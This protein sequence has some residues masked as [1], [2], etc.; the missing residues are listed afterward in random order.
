MVRMLRGLATGLMVALLLG[1]SA[2]AQ[3]IIYVKK[4]ATGANDGS[5]WADAYTSLQDALAAAQAG[6]EIWVAA[7]VYYPDEGTG[8][9]DNDRTLS[10]QMKSGVAIYGGFAG[11]ETDRSQRDWEA[12]PTVLSGDLDQNDI[13][14]DG[15]GKYELLRGNNSLHVVYVVADSLV[16]DG[17]KISG[18]IA[19]DISDNCGGGFYI[20]SSSNV[21][22]YNL[23]IEFNM[24]DQKGGGICVYNSNIEIKNSNIYSNKSGIGGGVY[25]NSSGGFSRFYSVIIEKNISNVGAGIYV[26]GYEAYLSIDDVYFVQ[27][28][29]DALFF[30]LVYGYMDILNSKFVHNKGRNI[31]MRG[32]KEC[33]ILNIEIEYGWGIDVYRSNLVVKNAVINE[34]GIV[35]EESSVVVD[36]VYVFGGIS[37]IKIFGSEA[38]VSNSII[39]HVVG[40]KYQQYSGQY[41][42][43]GGITISGSDPILYNVVIANN[44]ADYGGGIYVN[45][46][47]PQFFNVYVYN[48]MA[49]YDGGGMYIYKSNGSIAKNIILFNNKAVSSGGAI[50][51]KESNFV[52]WNNLSLIHNNADQGGG[53]Y[54]VDSFIALN[55]SLFANNVGK[56]CMGVLDLSSSNNVIQ[57]VASACGLQDGQN[58]NVIGRDARLVVTDDSTGI[59]RL[60]ADS[61]ALDAGDDSVC[62]TED[63]RGVERPQDGDEDGTPRCDIGALEFLPQ[64]LLH[65]PVAVAPVRPVSG[66][67]LRLSRSVLDTLWVSWPPATDADGDVLVYRWELGDTSMQHVYR[68]VWVGT[69][70]SVA[71]SHQELIALL[72]SLG[73]SVGEGRWLAHCVVVW[74]STMLAGG[75]RAEVAGTAQPL[76]L[77]IENSVP[78]LAE[79]LEPADGSVLEV[80]AGG[81]DTLRVVWGASWDA[82]GDALR[83]RWELS[84]EGDFARVWRRVETGDTLVVVLPSELWSLADSVGLGVG[85]RL[86]LYHRVVVSDGHTEV[87]GA[88]RRLELV[89][90]NS[91]PSPPAL[92]LPVVW[93]AVQIAGEPT[94]TL[95]IVWWGVRDPDGDPVYYRWEL[96]HDSLFAQVL[97]RRVTGRDTVVG[98]SYRELADLLDSL[99]TAPGQQQRLYHRV[100]AT[101]SSR[102]EGGDVR[103]VVGPAVPL[104][105]VR[106]QLTA[107]E[108]GLPDRIAFH[109]HYPNPVRAGVV[110]LLLDLPASSQV[111]VEV[112]DMLGRLVRRVPRSRLEAGR[113][114]RLQLEVDDLAAGMYVYRVLVASPGGTHE[115]F[116]G[117]LVRVR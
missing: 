76:F 42:R 64:E 97:R 50:Y 45:N 93:E 66:D 32:C 104:V 33:S 56:D 22:L 21:F 113:A 35:F 89:R 18:G 114:R 73:V 117:R 81:G 24:S 107:T 70:T 14:A 100:V 34:S 96:A 52:E 74:D 53:L 86:A 101:D 59:Y 77:Q 28:E 84:P 4:D 27:N 43:G 79:M 63:L 82:D 72:D 61:P 112:Y 1:T 37:G 49:R 99:G 30:S 78:A 115:V 16:L 67:T 23:Q 47:D 11:T 83:Y 57:D 46:G 51:V 65:L 95:Q 17:F 15:D 94:D 62:P 80:G 60:I 71:V 41:S 90:K 105:L 91:L 40:P 25:V 116:S 106:G 12:N 26:D 7:G 108:G 2:Q 20:L 44:V 85:E 103:E 39:A 6:D 8:L 9:T 87:L 5:S 54:S 36:S 102:V 10:F 111:A 88:A 31:F 38:V 75:K 69:D 68:R 13:D 48:N 58:G 29:K 3:R 110:E 55:N 19:S 109:G 98:L 92:E